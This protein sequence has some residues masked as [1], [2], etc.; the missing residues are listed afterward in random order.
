[1][2][3][4]AH[5]AP[6]LALAEH[7]DPRNGRVTVDYAATWVGVRPYTG[8][9]GELER[10]LHDPAQIFAPAF[11]DTLRRLPCTLGHPSVGDQPGWVH[12]DDRAPAPPGYR[13]V[14]AR[15]VT[16][17][18][19]GEEITPTGAG[20]Y[21]AEVPV[22]RVTVIDPDAIAR[23]QAGQR[24]SS[25]GYDVFVDYTP[26]IWVAPDGSRHPYDAV[27]VLDPRDPRVIYALERGVLDP[28]DVAHFG[29]NHLAIA[30][31]RGRGG[32]QSR[33][34]LDAADGTGVLRR[35]RPIP[36]RF[37]VAGGVADD[38]GEGVRFDDGSAAVHW[39][40][41]GSR[42][43]TAADFAGLGPVRWADAEFEIKLEI[44]LEGPKEEETE[45]T[46]SENE[47]AESGLSPEAAARALALTWDG[48]ARPEVAAD[49]PAIAAAR[50]AERSPLDDGGPWS[51]WSAG[52]WGYAVWAPSGDGLAWVGGDPVL[53]EAPVA[54]LTPQG[55][56]RYS[57]AVATLKIPAPLRVSDAEVTITI[58]DDPAMQAAL[59][60]VLSGA[61]AKISALETANAG[62]QTANTELQ[63][64]L[65]A[66][67][68]EA[69][70]AEAEKTELRADAL[71]GRQAALDAARA[72]AT[73]LGVEVAADAADAVAVQTAIV[74]KLAPLALDG[75]DPA[76]V[77][78]RMAVAAAYRAIAATHPSAPTPSTSAAGKPRTPATPI[79]RDSADAGPAPRT[80]NPNSPA[81]RA[82]RV[83]GVPAAD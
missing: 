28:E 49:V 61:A 7:T 66:A 80:R 32:V 70:K 5:D 27:H 34:R 3:F 43:Y 10:H 56:G 37:W 41:A 48:V 19:T 46:E 14:R 50:A 9:D 21:A 24:E 64:Q 78:G 71:A 79:A 4:H 25:L 31:A 33:I 67:E 13:I 39:R 18:Y 83:S 62:L 69:E 76:T 16:V 52:P 68:A 54:G 81:A 38:V 23:I 1:M 22:L 77:T 55:A 35:R 42:L 29:A 60:A 45:E 75:L 17:G 59:S 57:G 44:E 82:R 11:L 2:I 6:A 73:R 20:E 15:D 12:V 30:I 47:P 58:P 72:Q 40:A 74:R 65:E 53:V 8:P 63:T 51:S 26:G 36:R